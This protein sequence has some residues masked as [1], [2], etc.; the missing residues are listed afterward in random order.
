MARYKIDTSF[1]GSEQSLVAAGGYKTMLVVTAATGA[2]TLRRGWVDEFTCGIDGLPAATDGQIIYDWSLCTT[3]GTSTAIT[4]FPSE[5]SDAA[6]LLTYGANATI[7]PSVATANSKHAI[8]LNQRQS[9]HWWAMDMSKALV[10]PAANTN[11]IAGRA[12][13]TGTGSYASTIFMSENVTE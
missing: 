2:T 9:Y 1:G 8:V 5:G 4:P 13:S 11:G 6:A 10:I 12:K 3:A 7:E